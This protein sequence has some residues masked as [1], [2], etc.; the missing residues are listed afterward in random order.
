M[1]I[2]LVAFCVMCKNCFALAQGTFGKQLFTLPTKRQPTSDK[3]VQN[4]QRSP[5]VL[6]I[7]QSHLKLESAGEQLSVQRAWF[8]QGEDKQPCQN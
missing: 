6:S 5:Y 3:P 4:S 1:Y 8:L 7:V 2:W